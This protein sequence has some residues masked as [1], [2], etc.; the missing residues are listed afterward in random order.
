V[1]RGKSVSVMK[2]ST[3]PATR[4]RSNTHEETGPDRRAFLR[5]AGG[6]AI[7]LLI[8]SAVP[9]SALAAE[10]WQSPG[11]PRAPLKGAC[12]DAETDIE[13]T[14]EAILDA[15]VP[16]GASDPDGAPGAVEGCALNLMVDDEYP[17]KAYASLITTLM[18]ST[19]QKDH[20]ARFIELS[21]AQRLEVLVAAE[22]SLPLLRLAYRAIRSA[23]Y[24]GAYNGV[25]QEFLSY[26]GPNLGY[27]HLPEASFRRPVCREL[28]EEGWMP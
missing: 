2:T 26:P 22:E 23:F 28:T 16:G 9:R 17:F 19:A 27:R 18:D 3:T 21:L 15:V 10:A 6:W 1:D 7:G 24:G 5:Q 14:L 20:G 12:L 25:G 13:K 8:G 11:Y 4:Q